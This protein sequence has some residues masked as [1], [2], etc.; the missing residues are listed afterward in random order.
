MTNIKKLCVIASSYPTKHDPKNPFIDQLVVAFTNLGIKCT[1]INPVSLTNSLIRKSDLRPKKWFK[2]TEAGVINIYSPRYVSFSSKKIGIFNTNY[3]NLKLFQQSCIRVLKKI[4]TDFDAVYGHFIFPAGITA[5]YISE[6][7]NIPSFFAYGEN[8]NYTIDYLGVE[9]TRELLTNIKGIV[10]VS[11]A[12]KERLIK[13]KIVSSDKI[14]VFPN[15]INNKLFYKRNKKAMRNKYGFPED[16]FIV[17]FVGRFVEVKGANRLSK[18]IEMVGTDKIKSVF[19]GF[20]NVR[21]TCDGILLE[22]KQPHDNIP[23][24]LSAADVF[25]LPTLAEGSSNAIVE[26]LA[27][28]LPVISSNMPFN[29]DIL[30]DTCSIR[31]DPLNIEDI[32]NAIKLLYENNEL[33]RTLSHGALIKAQSLN[34][35]SRAKKILS[36]MESKLKS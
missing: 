7:Y 2:K 12:N 13:Q 20:G 30:D 27:C 25:V 16:A 10:S 17:A 23:E 22:G 5:N 34:I 32:A 1:V 24:I 18:A 3:I 4:G 28:G 14:E 31:I 26:A 33:R 6:K 29:D 36:F 21:P 11:T 19:I 8:T 15:A 35:E 9:K